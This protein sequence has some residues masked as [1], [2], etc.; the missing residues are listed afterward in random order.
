MIKATKAIVTTLVGD[1]Y[2]AKSKD[3]RFIVVD[4]EGQA[5][6]LLLP[7]LCKAGEVFKDTPNYVHA[8]NARSAAYLKD[9]H[10]YCPSAWKHAEVFDAWVNKGGPRP[11]PRAVARAVKFL[12]L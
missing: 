10:T 6:N 4:T 12:D 9:Q 7:D 2:L 1:K 3:G 11:V 8:C 5:D